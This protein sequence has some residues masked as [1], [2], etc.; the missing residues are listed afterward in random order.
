M[1]STL[2]GHPAAIA[3]HVLGRSAVATLWHTCT[4]HAEQA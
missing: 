3:V 1:L 4:T 2:S